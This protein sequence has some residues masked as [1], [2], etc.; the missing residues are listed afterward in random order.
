MSKDEKD[1]DGSGGGDDKEEANIQ[2]FVRIRPSKSPSGYIAMDS[3]HPGIQA[4]PAIISAIIILHYSQLFIAF[5]SY[6]I[7]FR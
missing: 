4:S 7:Y 3:E 5:A 6:F 2:T 1:A